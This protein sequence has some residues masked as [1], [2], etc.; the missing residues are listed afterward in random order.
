MGFNIGGKCLCCGPGSANETL[1][2]ASQR[3]R[4]LQINAPI[5]ASSTGTIF[6]YPLRVQCTRNPCSSL[7]RAQ[8]GGALVQ[9]VVLG[10]FVVSGLAVGLALFGEP[11]GAGTGTVGC[12]VLARVSGEDG[13]GC[14]AR[15]SLAP[16]DP[17]ALKR[18]S[19]GNGSGEAE[20]FTDARFHTG[21]PVPLL[22]MNDVAGLSKRGDLG[23]R[24]AMATAR[25]GDFGR[26]GDF[27]LGRPLTAE[28]RYALTGVRPTSQGQGVIAKLAYDQTVQ[29]DAARLFG[30]GTKSFLKKGVPVP[31]RMLSAWLVGD[32]PAE[33]ELPDELEVMP[34]IP[35][36]GVTFV[37]KR[38]GRGLAASGPWA[39]Q[40]RP[41]ECEDG[42]CDG[43]TFALTRGE[44]QTPMFQTVP[45]GDVM[46]VVNPE[47]GRSGVPS[48][49]AAKAGELATK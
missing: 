35:A 23:K 48:V 22:A 29:T 28:E 6:A 10:G 25:F 7:L 21:Q 32:D 30:T 3:D 45:D 40:V 46:L 19:L 4:S 2:V 49:D 39:L 44:G 42:A 26:A 17:E 1:E 43:V 12:R 5:N 13:S 9:Y 20:R 34:E 31:L 36:P 41:T 14:G 15:A 16:A 27:G 33:D 38:Q 37:L 11:F 24:Q 8:A 47:T 18:E